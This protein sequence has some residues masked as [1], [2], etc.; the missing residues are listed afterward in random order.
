MLRVLIVED[1]NI[2]GRSIAV[3]LAR[4]GLE[5][6][7]VTDTFAALDRLDQRKYTAIV[8]GI[9]MPAGMPNG[10]SL[11][12]MARVRDPKCRIIF[13][14]GDAELAKLGETFGARVFVKPVDVDAL[15]T[16]IIQGLR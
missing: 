3:C 10:L 5:V 2:L 4:E 12:R 16:H 9:G 13:I 15:L 8:A 14:A 11:G 6:D 1:D 7:A